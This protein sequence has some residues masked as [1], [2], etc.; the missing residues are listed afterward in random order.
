MMSEAVS[1]EQALTFG[2]R[3]LVGEQL[4]QTVI[5]VWNGKTNT[6]AMYRAF[7]GHSQIVCTIVEHNSDNQYLSENICTPV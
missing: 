2:S 4:N 5:K 3:M 7:A 1:T 6:V